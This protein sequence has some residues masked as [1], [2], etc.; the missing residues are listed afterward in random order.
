MVLPLLIILSLVIGAFVAF[1]EPIIDK[2]FTTE[3]EKEADAEAAKVLEEKGAFQNLADYLFGT[4]DQVLIE[5]TPEELEAEQEIKTAQLEDALEDIFGQQ[6]VADLQGVNLATGEKT[7]EATEKALDIPPNTDPF[8]A[9]NDWFVGG[10]E[11]FRDA[12]GIFTLG[13][14]LDFTES[15]SKEQS[16]GTAIETPETVDTANVE[17]LDPSPTIEESNEVSRATRFSSNNIDPEE[18]P[19]EGTMNPEEING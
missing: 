17:T 7:E 11:E 12:G 3:A 19:E 18:T 13:G 10:I 15:D 4:K 9:F 16:T 8:Q 5:Q 1:R 2:F 6:A 14:I